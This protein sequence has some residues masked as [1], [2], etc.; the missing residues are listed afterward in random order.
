MTAAA[1]AGATHTV[2]SISSR[3]IRIS[4]ATAAEHG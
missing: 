4:A 1:A 3:S 2:S